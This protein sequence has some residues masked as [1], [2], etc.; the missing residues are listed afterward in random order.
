MSK[1]DFDASLGTWNLL[2]LIY[3]H[4]KINKISSDKDINLKYLSIYLNIMLSF[5]MRV[6][7]CVISWMF[8][9]L[10]IHMSKCYILLIW[11]C[12][13][14]RNA[15]FFLT[16]MWCI[17]VDMKSYAATYVIMV[18]PAN[19]ITFLQSTSFQYLIYNLRLSQ[20]LSKQKDWV[21]LL[22]VVVCFFFN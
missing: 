12:M 11:T 22:T 6:H 18:C 2:S 3:F 4:K 7:T 20:L 16:I 5:E 19:K 8:L 15:Q 17:Y 21:S 10:R 1:S 13:S 14:V 9:N